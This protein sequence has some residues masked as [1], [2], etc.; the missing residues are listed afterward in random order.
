MLGRDQVAPLAISLG[1]ERF[2]LFP[3]ISDQQRCR[4]RS[5]NPLWAHK[6]P[7]LL[8]DW[9]R[10][11][12]FSSAGQGETWGKRGCSGTSGD[13]GSDPGEA[14]QIPVRLP[15]HISCSSPYLLPSSH[16]NLPNIYTLE[17]T[18]SLA[19]DTWSFLYFL[20]PQ[21][22]YRGQQVQLI[23]IR[24]PWGQVEWNGPWSDKCVRCPVHTGLAKAKSQLLL[25]K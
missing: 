24:N 19:T 6:R 4:V 10:W 16:S 20:L 25:H 17:K 15:S 1:R 8:R 13:A 21:V 9:H 2:T 11:G 23:R 5:Q 12:T 14:V 18:C 22:S 7:C 3:Y